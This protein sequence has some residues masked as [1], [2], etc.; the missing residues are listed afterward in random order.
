MTIQ[1]LA[2]YFLTRYPDRA[3]SV[4]TPQEPVSAPASPPG[5]PAAARGNGIEEMRFKS[6]GSLQDMVMQLS[7]AEVDALLGMLAK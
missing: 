4:F 5:E 2:D 1:K 7:D 3:A 6:T